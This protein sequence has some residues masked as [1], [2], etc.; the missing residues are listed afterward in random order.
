MRRVIMIVTAMAV[1]ASCGGGEATEEDARPSRTEAG[2]FGHDDEPFAEDLFRDL[3]GYYGNE[4]AAHGWVRWDSMLGWRVRDGESEHVNVIDGAR[5]TI[6]PPASSSPFAGRP[7]R[8]WFF[9]GSTMF[10]LGQRDD[11]TIPSELVRLAAEDGLVIE[12]VNLGVMAYVNWQEVMAFSE[13]LTRGD[14]A[15]LAVFYDG[16]NEASTADQRAELGDVDDRRIARQLVSEHDIDKVK[17]EVRIDGGPREAGVDGVPIAAQQYVRGVEL[18]QAIG[19]AYGVPTAF[20]WQP[21]LLT[22]RMTEH[23]REAADAV[24]VEF[25]PQGGPNVVL[26]EILELG[27]NPIDLT[28][29]LDGVDRPVYLDRAHTNE[30]G[31]AVIAGALY[32]A[33]RPQLLELAGS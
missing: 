21:S 26:D 5:R 17:D 2:P 33:L 15:D 16:A 25:M 8:V 22:K 27:A 10:G 23:D 14:T 29:A 9:G 31:A 7:L 32:E 12:A 20:V 1:I 24:G 19:T 13:R 4:G 18:A 30:Y 11:H 3:N 28:T 6:A